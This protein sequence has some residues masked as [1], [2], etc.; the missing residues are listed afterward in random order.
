M[1]FGLLVL[2]GEFTGGG[3]MS[4][5]VGGLVDAIGW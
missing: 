3:V 1:R 5:G 2:S 4:V